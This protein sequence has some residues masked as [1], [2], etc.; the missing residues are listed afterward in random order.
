MLT[1][2][3]W[4]FSNK[5]YSRI[6]EN[7]ELEETDFDK[8]QFEKPYGILYALFP[9]LRFEIIHPSHNSLCS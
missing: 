7:V 8:K 4:L 1:F 6:L 9:E 3:K 5:V 2:L